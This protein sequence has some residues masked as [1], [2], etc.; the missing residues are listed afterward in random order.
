VILFRRAFRAA[1]YL[2]IVSY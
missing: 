2:P 1:F